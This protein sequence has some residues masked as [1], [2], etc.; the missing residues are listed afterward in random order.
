[1]HPDELE[2][3][4]VYHAPDGD[5]RELHD[6]IRA[7]FLAFALDLAA[8]IR[9]DTSREV[10]LTFTALEEASFWMHAHIA[11]NR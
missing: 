4:F 5:T 8:A 2:H 11:R 9:P 3:R 6:A 7:K 1:M 10:S